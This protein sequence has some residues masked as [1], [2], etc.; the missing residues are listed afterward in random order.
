M[1]YTSYIELSS[2]GFTDMI[3][4]TGKV[5]SVL[6]KSGI[7]NGLLTVFVNGSTAAATTIEF[8]DGVLQDLKEAVERLFPSNITYKHDAAW[9]DG[10]GF[11]HVRAAFMKPDITIPV[12]GGGMTLG[13]WQQIVF[14]DFD[15]R[16]R[17]RRIIVQV[18]GDE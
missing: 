6:M 5:E 13:T 18:V 8:E 17:K 16:P 2:K 10:N 7:K 9:G 14:I 11:A 3:D 1:H 15:N 12:V 4:I